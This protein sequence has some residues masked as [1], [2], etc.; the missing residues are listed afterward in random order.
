MSTKNKQC[1]DGASVTNNKYKEIVQTAI[2]RWVD[3]FESGRIKLSTVDDL[4]KLIELDME[5][6]KRGLSK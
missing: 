6:Q 3:D 5:L 1:D 2:E 4:Q